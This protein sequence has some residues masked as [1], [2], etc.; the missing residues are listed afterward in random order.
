MR[1]KAFAS[2]EQLG[3]VQVFLALVFFL[4]CL[5]SIV[6]FTTQYSII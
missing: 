6:V 2:V 4:L 5:I 1:I 3:T